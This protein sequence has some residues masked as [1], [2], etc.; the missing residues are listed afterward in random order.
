MIKAVLAITL[1]ASPFGAM[2]Q[3]VG[4]APAAAPP[5]SLAEAAPLPD[6]PLPGT[7]SPAAAPQAE[8]PADLQ[9]C[10]QETGDFVSRGKSVDYV[11]GIA[12]T[13]GMRLRCEIFANVNAA[14]GISQGHTIMTLG[15]AA[16]GDAAKKTY[17]MRVKAAGGIIQ[18]SRECKVL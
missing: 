8:A 16:S 7:A 15:P 1:C 4:V 13:C 9:S 12:N 5:Q 17:T 10:L 3:S 18:V 2:A 11:I 14:R 6:N